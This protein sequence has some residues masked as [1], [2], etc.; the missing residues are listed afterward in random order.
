MW[1]KGSLESKDF[2]ARFLYNNQE[3]ISTDD[4]GFINFEKTK[5][6]KKFRPPFTHQKQKAHFRVRFSLIKMVTWDT[7]ALANT[8]WLQFFCL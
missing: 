8:A 4:G 1:F 7:I 5:A 3:I 2:E 6:N